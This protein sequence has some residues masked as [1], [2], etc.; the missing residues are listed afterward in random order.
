MKITK[1]TVAY[2]YRQG[3]GW[4]VGTWSTQHKA[5]FISPE[6]GYWDACECVRTARETW[7]TKSQEYVPIF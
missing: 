6:K 2:K 5:Y 7:D 4:V 3:S 1:K